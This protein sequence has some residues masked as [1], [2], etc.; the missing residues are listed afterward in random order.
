MLN[1]L[2]NTNQNKIQVLRCQNIDNEGLDTA[3]SQSRM[4][5]FLMSNRNMMTN[6][7]WKCFALSVFL[8]MSQYSMFSIE[9]KARYEYLLYENFEK[10]KLLKIEE[11][12]IVQKLNMFR[13]EINQII[14]MG[15]Y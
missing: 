5:I 2:H 11:Q 12:K 14:C 3:V 1:E 15:N 9:E 4:L 6:I 10:T 8:A 13:F 7:C